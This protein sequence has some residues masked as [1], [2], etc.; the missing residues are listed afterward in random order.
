MVAVRGVAVAVVR[1]VDVIPVRHRIVS[2]AR[3]VHVAVLPM[4]QVRQRMLIVMPVVGCMS[5]AI[6]NVVS[7]TLTLGTRMPAIRAVL[8]L[9]MEMRLVVSGFHGSSLL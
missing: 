1:V 9:R 4:G 5:V 3:S 6:M 7:V 8:M 2:A